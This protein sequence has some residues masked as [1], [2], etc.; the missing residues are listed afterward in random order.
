MSAFEQHRTAHLTTHSTAVAAPPERVYRIIADVTGWPQY[1]APNVHVE[2]LESH[3]RSE[4]IRIWATANGEVKSWTSRREL[5]PEGLRIRFRQEVSQPPVAAMGGEWLVHAVDGGGSLLELKHDFSA[6]DDTPEGVDWITR[7]VDRNSA[8]ELAGIKE[9]AELGDGLSELVF[10]FEDTV[11]VAGDGGDVFAFLDR[12]DLWP[13]RLPHVARLDLTEAAPGLQV[14]AMDTRTADGSVHTTES[15][16]VCFAPDRIVYKQTA[17]PALMAAHTGHWRITPD[18]EGV[19]VT[20]G[21][22]VTL[23]PS[24]IE[25]VLGPGKTVAD[26]R[27]F[28]HRALSTNSSTTLRH[29]KAYAEGL[30]R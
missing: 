15:V 20:S 11:R 7:A 17:V 22:T 14:M 8:A 4:R 10:S 28:I 29:A 27:A 3:G 21:H 12:A 13:E 9:L 2:I 16:R 24:A 23:K 30:R 6:V 18:A 25:A 26:A 1:F 19:S 5:D